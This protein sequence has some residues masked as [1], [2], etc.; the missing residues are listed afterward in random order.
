MADSRVGQGTSKMILKTLTVPESKGVLKT[1][2]KTCDILKGHRDQFERAP[3]D[4][5]WKNLNKK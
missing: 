1:Q 3:N 2:R 4:P 5:R